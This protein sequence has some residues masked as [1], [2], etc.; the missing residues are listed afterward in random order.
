MSANSR[1]KNSGTTKK[2]YGSPICSLMM[3]FN[4]FKGAKYEIF[5]LPGLDE[6]NR[7]IYGV[8]LRLEGAKEMPIH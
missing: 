4:Y 2:I 1:T 8:D 5:F 7:K 6:A 3:T